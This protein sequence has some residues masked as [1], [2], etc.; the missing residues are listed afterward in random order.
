MNIKYFTVD[1]V[2]G[3][4][5]WHAHRANP[6]VCNASELTVAMGISTK[7][8]RDDLVKAK[9][10]GIAIAHSDFVEQRVFAPGHTFEEIAR[11]WADEI[12]GEDLYSGVF[13]A[14]VDGLILSASL[15]GHTMLGRT[16]W[17]HK[18]LNAELAASLEA[19]VIPDEYH[20]QME[21]GFLCNPDATKCL[22]MASSGNKKTMRYTWYYPNPELRAKIIPAWKQLMADVAAYTPTVQ[23]I[24]PVGRTPE[25]LPALRASVTGEL[26]L[27]ANIKEWEAAALEYIQAVRSH[28][29]KTDQDFE[30]ADAATKWC[31]SSKTKLEGLKS[32]LMSSTGDVN[33]AVE[34]IDR[35]IGEL[36]KTRIQFTKANTTR[37]SERKAEI[38]AGG[39]AAFAK[40][41][42]ELNASMP[43]EY[44]PKIATD[45]GGCI[46]NLRTFASIQN[47]VNSELARAKI[48]ADE[49]AARIRKNVDTIKASGLLV[50]DTSTLV[51]KAPDD[52][53]A[54]LA[55]RKAE[56]DARDAALL[57]Q[58]QARLESDALAKLAATTAAAKPAQVEPQQSSQNEADELDRP[59][60]YTLA[61]APPCHQ[62]IVAPAPAQATNVTPITHQQQTLIPGHQRAAANNQ[63]EDDGVRIKLGDLNAL[64]AP[65]SITADGLATLGY[66]PVSTGG[67]AKL[68]RECDVPAI[69]QTMVRH[70]NACMA[71]RLLAA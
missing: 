2:Q 59:R 36:D 69:A 65:M 51:L 68:Y 57:A 29:L 55:Q 52:L 62:T 61:T 30:D 50:T 28:E 8:R 70:L 58:E 39:V 32:N 5:E 12:I 14:E 23:E 45:F 56:Q 25:S 9:A 17:E 43:A 7:M 63:P 41:V 35:I 4:P 34:T 40:H 1:H 49:V 60:E 13:C 46:K 42:A 21:Q 33:T 54:V 38:V 18:Q 64:I 37:K 20:P 67:S 15:D 66:P 53:A 31:D 16:N 26:V 3:S 24:K 19:G 10:T 44:M 47:A 11:P 22:F 27:E 6:V 48:A 71:K